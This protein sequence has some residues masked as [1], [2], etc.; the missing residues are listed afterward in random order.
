MGIALMLTVVTGFDYVLRAV[1][2][3]AA[4]RR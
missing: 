2:L 3:R 4:G 1:R